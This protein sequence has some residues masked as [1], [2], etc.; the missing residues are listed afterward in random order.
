MDHGNHAELSEV[1]E[2]P[3]DLA[4]IPPLAQ[5]AALL[6]PA[7]PAGQWSDGATEALMDFLDGRPLK[8][9]QVSDC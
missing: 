1:R 9:H 4:E 6:H 3:A 7:G 8:I 5:R 2:L